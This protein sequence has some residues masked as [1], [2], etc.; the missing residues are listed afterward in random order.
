MKK[1]IQNR[2]YI[3]S[4]RPNLFEPNVYISM[5]VTFSST[6]SQKELEQAVKAA[7]AHN[8]AAMS[9]IVLEG[10]GEAYYETMEQS[11]CKVFLEQRDWKELLKE[12]ENSLLWE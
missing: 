6:V 8:E 7:C 10:S 5:V 2:N 3:T 12:S 1:N 4:E 11:G 9:K